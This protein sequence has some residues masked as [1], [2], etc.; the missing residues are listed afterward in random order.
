MMRSIG[1]GALMR[2]LTG[3]LMYSLVHQMI[4]IQRTLRPRSYKFVSAMFTNRSRYV[5][6]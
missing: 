1:I 5:Y 2:F 6:N 3:G 4:T